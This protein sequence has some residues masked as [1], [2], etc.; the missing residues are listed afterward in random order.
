MRFNTVPWM[1]WSPQ[2]D[3]LAYF[4]RTEKDR[5]LIL[6]NVISRKVE[7]RI[8]MNTV[9]S[10]ESPDISPD[11]KLVAF[12]A[13]R[14]IINDIYTVNL[15]DQGNRQPHQGR[16]RRLRA[17]LGA[18]RQVDRLPQ[19][20]ERQREAVPARSRVG[21]VDAAHLR[22][23]RRRRRAVPRRRHAGLHVDGDRSGQGRSI[24]TSPRTAPSTTS[25]RST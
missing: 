5:S 3:R 15:D 4:V 18:R 14:G 25:G 24:P 8:P 11:G 17:D 19:A 10:P 9:D 20:R 12:S 13:A 7:V 22:H 23:A 2:G 16:V 1:S 6:Q 21:Q